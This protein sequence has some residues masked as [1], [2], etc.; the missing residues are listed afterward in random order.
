MDVLEK[1]AAPQSRKFCQRTADAVR[2]IWR[3]IVWLADE[4]FGADPV[5]AREV[6]ERLI[7]AKLDLSLNLNMTA[8]DVV[9]DAELLPLYKAAGVDYIVMG[10]KSLQDDVVASV[11]KNNPYAISRRAVPLFSENHIISLVN[12][13]YGLEEEN[14]GAMSSTSK[15]SLHSTPTF[16]TLS[17]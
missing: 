7:A 17:T 10:V 1:V 3:Q 11:R 9:R 16:S 5:A 6:L 13:I 15:K 12:I 8:A 14:A 2:K 4:N